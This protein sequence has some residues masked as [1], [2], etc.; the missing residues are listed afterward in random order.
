[1]MA[2]GGLD[3]RDAPIR[4]RNGKALHV[5]E[6]SRR[7]IGSPPIAAAASTMSGRAP[8]SRRRRAPWRCCAKRGAGRDRPT[9]SRSASP[10]TSAPDAP[11]R[12]SAIRLPTS[13]AAGRLRSRPKA[14]GVK[15]V[16]P[17]AA[18]GAGSSRPPWPPASRKPGDGLF[19]PEGVDEQ[20]QSFGPGLSPG[21]QKEL[22]GKSKFRPVRKSRAD[23]LPQTSAW[24][25]IGWISTVRTCTARSGR[26]RRASP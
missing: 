8:R 15:A 9:M 19:R 26:R 16:T 22:D 13:S 3:R 11:M 4:A 10:S 20:G 2:T 18:I 1:M 24:I 25:S 5:V 6:L 7:R 17:S 12:P 21:R 14:C 23:A